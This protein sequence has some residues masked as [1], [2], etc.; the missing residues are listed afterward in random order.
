MKNETSYNHVGL[1][2]FLFLSSIILCVMILSTIIEHL[3]KRQIKED[4]WQKFLRKNQSH[5]I[6]IQNL[7]D[8]DHFE[9]SGSLYR[10]IKSKINR[11]CLKVLEEY[12]KP[13][14]KK[15]HLN[16]RVSQKST[17]IHALLEDQRCIEAY[18][19]TQD[20]LHE[21][22]SADL[23]LL[24]NPQRIIE[25]KSIYIELIQQICEKRQDIQERINATSYLIQSQQYD[26]LLCKFDELLRELQQW[27]FTVLKKELNERY[28]LFLKFQ[29]TSN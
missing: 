26:L 29:K 2:L 25:L 9:E 4:L 8:A 3:K 24:H 10:A 7:C 13:V 16:L 23:S 18:Q 22:E 15:N 27:L 6:H 19:K 5:L 14:L 11:S 1:V 17:Q 28:H 21:I 12:L 20:I